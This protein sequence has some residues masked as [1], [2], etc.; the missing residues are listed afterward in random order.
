MRKKIPNQKI[1]VER[2][3]YE[4]LINETIFRNLY[5]QQVYFV[6]TDLKSKNYF[7]LGFN[8]D[9][10][11]TAGKNLIRI[12]G[13]PGMLAVNTPLLIEAVDRTGLPLKTSIYD[14]KNETSDKVICIEVHEAT[15][16]GDIRLTLVGSALRDPN[17]KQLPPAWQNEMNFKW[18]QT[19]EARPFTANRSDILFNEETTPVITINEVIKPYNKLIYNQELVTTM[20]GTTSNNTTSR[21]RLQ[22]GQNTRSKISYRKSGGHYFITAHAFENNILDFGGFTKDM[23]GGVL[24]VA[25]PLNPRPRSV[26]GYD[27][28]QV[29]SPKET[30]DGFRIVV[31]IDAPS[32]SL[33]TTTSGTCWSDE[34]EDQFN[35]EVYIAGAYQT[36]VLEFI[37]PWE[38]RVRDPHTTWQGLKEETHRLFEH[39]EFQ[40]SMYRL[41]WNQKPQSCKPTPLH[42]QTSSYGVYESMKNSY[43][44]VK[45]T[46][47][48]P[49]SGDVTRIKSYTRNN[50]SPADWRL[51]S[52]MTVSAKEMLFCDKETCT[53]PSG[54]FSRWGVGD[55]GIIG[56]LPYWDAEGIGNFGGNLADPALSLYYQQGADDAPPTPDS[57]VVGNNSGSTNLTGDNHWILYSKIFPKFKKGKMYQLEI[58]SVSTKTQ[59]TAWLPSTEP[60][61]DP[62]IEVY[63]SG[64]S[65]I[66]DINDK[67]NYGK[68]VGSIQT[69]ADK[70]KHVEQ[71]RYNKDLTKGYKFLFVADEDGSGKPLIKIN[72]GLWQFWNISLKPLDLFG[73]TPEEF[74]ITFPTEKTDVKES[75]AIDFKF[76]FYNDYGTIANYTA[77]IN[78]INWENEHT[79]VFD[80]IVVNKLYADFLISTSSIEN[81]QPV[82]FSAGIYVEGDT[83]IGTHCTQSLILNADVQLPCLENS[84]GRL[85][86]YDPNTDRLTYSTTMSQNFGAATT[87]L[88]QQSWNTLVGDIGNVQ[89]AGL[90][91]TLTIVGDGGLIKTWSTG[92]NFVVGENSTPTFSTPVT[93][94]AGFSS[95]SSSYFSGSVSMSGKI[96]I[97]ICCTDDVTIRGD[98][99]MKCLDH[100]SAPEYVL[101]YD[102]PTRTVYYSDMPTGGG[103]STVN[104]CGTAFTTIGYDL[105]A[106]WAE[107]NPISIF[108]ASSCNDRFYLLPGEGVLFATYSQG[109]DDGLVISA[110]RLDN[111]W[112]FIVADNG[113]GGNI[114]N[115]DETLFI[116]GSGGI[117]VE[118]GYSQSG[119]ASVVVVEIDGSAI[120]ATGGVSSISSTDGVDST[121]RA[122]TANT[123]AL[124][125]VTVDVF[126][127]DGGT[128]IGYVPSGSG[129]DNKKFLNGAG[130]WTI[131]SP[132]G[133]T[134]IAASGTTGLTVPITATTVGTATTIRV[135]QFGG[136]NSV[137]YVPSSLGEDQKNAFL[138]ADGTW[139]A[140][141]ISG[142]YQTSFKWH[143][144]GV[145][146]A[147]GWYSYGNV[148][149]QGFWNFNQYGD[150]G[151]MVVPLGV[152]NPAFWSPAVAFGA[153]IFNNALPQGAST[154]CAKSATA[155]RLCHAHLTFIS[156]NPG[157]YTIELFKWDPCKTGTTIVKVGGTTTN[158]SGGSE[159]VVCSD[160]NLDPAETQLV[161]TQAL[162][163]A[164]STKSQ[165]IPN[166]KTSAMIDLRWQYETAPAVPHHGA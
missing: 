90:N 58:S 128:N 17:G 73:F 111:A 48:T 134:S 166:T 83:T 109:T 151:Q 78:N 54:D 63:L 139:E 148:T 145:G 71:D 156:N 86:T 147:D 96:D 146:D 37:S 92:S 5:N 153:T 159:E 69:A 24:I 112:S 42:E 120:T 18:S 74:E 53:T 60:L 91:S 7:K 12:Q 23:V 84:D 50:Q 25:E 136:A 15:P 129:G 33:P 38:I 124:G 164:V 32:G 10:I 106:N 137:G 36:V 64:S 118:A 108:T 3:Q 87:S 26:A 62:S 29:Y 72:S 135:N 31:P 123:N 102:Y 103:T 152:T 89:A 142:N 65:F 8:S 155:N 79:A 114:L 95:P 98:I 165:N 130:D 160:F 70:E 80:N 4:S 121:G 28:P 154:G 56:V 61:G 46:N 76:E 68:K 97:G 115:H 30:G 20:G 75:E 126:A 19:F 66:D 113:T 100:W 101:S 41:I 6:D 144:I 116:T 132:S 82:T 77:E 163:F 131:V 49:A 51:V 104:G 47:L 67:Y 40:P 22:T 52:D 21:Y 158:Q 9:M 117:V 110:P 85:V 11:F 150:P 13:K 81:L 88:V 2:L 39:T 14:L 27:A 44:H 119:G 161:G 162:F 157:S 45:L 43:A 140:P 1:K 16:P 143:G 122:I 149:S 141:L 55:E 99:K 93:A 35:T 127:Y 125:A 133:L 107:G 34:S 105:N 57:L 94:S 59:P 138:R